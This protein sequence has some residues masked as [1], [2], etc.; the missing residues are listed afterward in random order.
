MNN[1]RTE[2]CFDD[3]CCGSGE[4]GKSAVVSAASREPLA[5]CWYFS[6]LLLR[7][8]EKTAISAEQQQRPNERRWTTVA[9]AVAW[10]NPLNGR[11]E[12]RAPGKEEGRKEL[13]GRRKGGKEGRK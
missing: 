11:N 1:Q 5:R 2:V 13:L 9:G 3:N 7:A 8:A 4:S 12:R 6:S 10:W